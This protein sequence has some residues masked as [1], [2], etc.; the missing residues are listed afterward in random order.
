MEARKSY[1][2]LRSTTQISGIIILFGIS[3]LVACQSD[4]G[5]KPSRD[6]VD[7]GAFGKAQE[8][9]YSI[10]LSKHVDQNNQIKYELWKNSSE[11]FLALKQILFA[12]EKADVNAMNSD[13][14]K[15]FYINA[16]NVL[17]IDLILSNYDKTLGG[18]GSPYPDQRSIRNINNL[19]TKVW[20]AFRWKVSG[21]QMSLNEIEH[22]ILRP[23]GDARIHFAIVCASKGCPPILNRAFTAQDLDETLDE[24]AAKFVNSGKS[25]KFDLDKQKLIT[26][27]ILNWFAQDF[28]KTF[29]SVKNFF[30][31]Y[32][33]V[34]SPSLIPSLDI[35]YDSYDWTL[36]EPA[37][38]GSGT[39]D[40]P[41][42]GTETPPGSGTE[43]EI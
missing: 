4:L 27:H 12:I 13:E 6:Q 32:V 16:Y 8:E 33:T 24:L 23:M 43:E 36:N 41:G 20:D 35:S 30:S 28:V 39:E 19:D 26:S 15:T 7:A 21:K 31:K 42:S 11:D 10:L 38:P 37:A 40:P 2:F 34:I 5:E 9:S 3:V 29:G 17:T 22:Q 1:S 18:T 25:T 14:Q